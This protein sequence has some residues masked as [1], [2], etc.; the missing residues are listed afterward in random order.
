MPFTTHRRAERS[1]CCL[2][3]H[4]RPPAVWY[5]VAADRSR[6]LLTADEGLALLNSAWTAG[7]PHV[8]VAKTEPRERFERWAREPLTS[9]DA[10][11]RGDDERPTRERPSGGEHDV[12]HLIAGILSDLVGGA[13]LGPDDDFY[14]AGGHSLLAVQAAMQISVAMEC[15]VEPHMIL[16][17][18]MPKAIAERVE[19]AR[20]RLPATIR[21]SSCSAPGRTTS[22]PSY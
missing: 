7:P 14:D 3:C 15:E 18:R 20:R 11:A 13:E 9:I 6:L 4:P 8:L 19:R 22:R 17:G 10:R 21:A 2:R 5:E 1:R 16:D 12:A